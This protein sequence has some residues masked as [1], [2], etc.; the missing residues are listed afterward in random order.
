[1]VHLPTEILHPILWE[2]HCTWGVRI[3][4]LAT[5]NHHWQSVVEN[6]LWENLSITTKKIE[7]FISFTHGRYTRQHAVRSIYFE[8]KYFQKPAQ[9]ALSSEGTRS[10]ESDGEKE[11]S[12]DDCD[13]H[14]INTEASCE[15]MDGRGKD[16]TNDEGSSSD[17]EDNSEANR[18]SYDSDVE[19]IR[20]ELIANARSFWAFRTE[21]MRFMN[22]IYALWTEIASWDARLRVREIKIVVHGWSMYKHL[23]P[24]FRDYNVVQHHLHEENWLNAP[25]APLLP[26][27]HTVEKFIFKPE[28]NTDVGW[29]TAIVGCH[30][31]SSLAG[32][33]DLEIRSDDWERR[34]SHVR[35]ECRESE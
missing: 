17:E 34:W 18:S 5:V 7:S 3:A 12:L 15:G 14:S 35:R 20:Y 10:Q 4:P 28:V 8:A 16:N 6:I 27:L 23:G 25:D 19:S 9:I 33:E 32:L 2:L 30:I 22:D 21:H 31:A 29:W 26:V 1:M 13:E 11:G 24:G